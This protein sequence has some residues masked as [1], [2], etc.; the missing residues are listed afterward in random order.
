MVTETDTPSGGY[1]VPIHHQLSWWAAV[2]CLSIT[3]QLAALRFTQERWIHHEH[4][5]HTQISTNLRR[6]TNARGLKFSP[7]P[8]FPEDVFHILGGSWQSS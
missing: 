3:Q 1:I 7:F 2:Y 4:E 6:L 5:V 8:R